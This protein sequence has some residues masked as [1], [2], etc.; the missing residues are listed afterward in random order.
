MGSSPEPMSPANPFDEGVE[1]RLYDAI[2]RA[3]GP[4]AATA[5]AD[6][7]DCERDAVRAYLRSFAALGL[8]V[9]RRGEQTTYER[10]DAAFEW[11]EMMALAAEHSLKEI[12]AEQ[13]A[14]LERIRAYQKQFGVDAPDDLELPISDE[15]A[16]DVADWTDG[17]AALQRCERARQVL[18][19]DRDDRQ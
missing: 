12:E 14:L 2:V 3:D 8:V 4:L 5:L 19:S 15:A 7:V 18:L 9:P 6:R 11:E 1:E 17:R 13:A 16:D 10:N